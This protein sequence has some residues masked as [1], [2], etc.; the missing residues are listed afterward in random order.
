MERE[1]G[2]SGEAWGGGGRGEAGDRRVFEYE[3]ALRLKV[4]G[5]P[6]PTNQ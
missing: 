3:L 6:K 5:N 2:G 4:V 1:E